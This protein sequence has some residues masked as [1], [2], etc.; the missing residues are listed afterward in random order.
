MQ[1]DHSSVHH[2]ERGVCQQPAHRHWA[3]FDAAMLERSEPI[4]PKWSRERL[5][6]EHK[7][8]GMLVTPAITF[9]RLLG[10]RLARAA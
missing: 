3:I 8:N 9:G 7:T 5:A 6:Q 10:T 2:I 4:I 1:E